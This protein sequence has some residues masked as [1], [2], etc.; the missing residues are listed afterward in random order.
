MYTFQNYSI[1]NL[2]INLWP[3]LS[4]FTINVAPHPIFKYVINEM[5]WIYILT[6]ITSNISPHNNRPIILDYVHKHT[7]HL[8]HS[9]LLHYSLSNLSL[10]TNFSISIVNS[11]QPMYIIQTK[12]INDTFCQPYTVKF[13]KRRKCVQKPKR[14]QEIKNKFSQV[15][16]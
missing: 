8:K 7:N 15:E 6:N 11:Q 4:I 10:T 1:N 3:T 14:T 12:Q 2:Y 16:N 5:S 9:T 13:R